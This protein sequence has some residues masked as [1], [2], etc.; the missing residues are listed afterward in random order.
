MLFE[1]FNY[2]IQKNHDNVPL[3]F[4]ERGKCDIFCFPKSN[5]CRHPDYF[6]ESIANT[7]F[8]GFIRMEYVLNLFFN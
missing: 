2:Q 8:A 4:N 7:A 6:R 3:C 1:C 5:R